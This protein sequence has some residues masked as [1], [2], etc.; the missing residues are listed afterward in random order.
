MRRLLRSLLLLPALLLL[1]S[2]CDGRSDSG[3]HRVSLPIADASLEPLSVPFWN[4]RVG[5][6]R[7]ELKILSKALG[8]GDYATAHASWLH[9]YRDIFEPQ[10]EAR[11]KGRMGDRERLQFEYAFGRLGYAL[12]AHDDS[13]AFEALVDLEARLKALPER[14]ATPRN[15]A[16]LSPSGMEPGFEGPPLPPRPATTEVP[17]LP[18]R[19][20]PSYP[21]AAVGKDP[22]PQRRATKQGK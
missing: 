18:P 4:V 20:T 12:E 8:A 21:E 3:A 15:D 19:T 6:V 14:L 13:K 2:T 16:A 11:A 5:A 22:R 10:I 7:A 17:A 1:A 9:A